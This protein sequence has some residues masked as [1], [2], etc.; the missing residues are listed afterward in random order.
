[1]ILQEKSFLTTVR[2]TMVFHGLKRAMD[3]VK[4]IAFYVLCL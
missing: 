2:V 1:M 4:T 3:R